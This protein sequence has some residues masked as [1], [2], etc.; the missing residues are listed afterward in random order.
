MNVFRFQRRDEVYRPFFF[1]AETAAENLLVFGRWNIQTEGSSHLY[2]FFFVENHATHLSDM[3]FL[4]NE[5]FVHKPP[6][7]RSVMP[8]MRTTYGYMLIS[9]ITQL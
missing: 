3:S 4:P 6:N 8:A 9:V 5:K 2:N 7:F 1:D